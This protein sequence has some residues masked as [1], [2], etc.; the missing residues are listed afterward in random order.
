MKKTPIILL[1]IVLLLLIATYFISYRN[2]TL[3]EDNVESAQV[4]Q[5]YTMA[6]S[7]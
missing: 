1:M 3:K 5:T 4:Y 6:Y 7:I 2:N